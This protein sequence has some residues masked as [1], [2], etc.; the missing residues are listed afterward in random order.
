MSAAGKRQRTLRELLRSD[1]E[2]LT[3]E[4]QR[5]VY[6]YHERPDPRVP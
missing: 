2:D 5:R 3:P 6:E 1:W 4:E